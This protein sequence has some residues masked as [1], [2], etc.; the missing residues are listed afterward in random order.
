MIAIGTK[1]INGNR[2]GSYMDF[3]SNLLQ[4][5]AFDPFLAE[6]ICRFQELVTSGHQN[7]Q[8]CRSAQPH[9]N[10]KF[11]TRLSL[12]HT[13]GDSSRR[14]HIYE[15][16]IIKAASFFQE[17]KMRKENDNFGFVRFTSGADLN[18]HTHY[19]LLCTAD[20]LTLLPL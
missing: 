8:F 16:S 14:N 1:M 15:A 2:T 13:N 3:D 6:N 17:D 4:W 7:S 9:Y 10:C 18:I 5:A 19:R 20:F 12:S 11:L